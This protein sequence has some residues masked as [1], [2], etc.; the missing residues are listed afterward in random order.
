[1][2]KILVNVEIV[3]SL[4]TIRILNNEKVFPDL[5]IAIADYG[6][7]YQNPCLVQNNQYV[8]PEVIEKQEVDYML[9]KQAEQE[10]NIK[11]K[12]T[13][14]KTNESTDVKGES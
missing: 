14:K 13:K 11:K 6:R 3:G 8:F 7:E 10:K 2:A 9:A 12:I 5:P 1:M 4:P